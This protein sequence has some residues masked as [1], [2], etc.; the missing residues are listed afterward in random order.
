MQL[1]SVVKEIGAQALSPK[2]QMVILFGDKAT[3][4]LR[5][6][7]VIQEF[8]DPSAQKKMTVKVGDHLYINQIK[9]RVIGVGG[10]TNANL[11]QIGHATL[12]F[13]PVP[14]EDQLGN[15]IYLTPTAKP[16]FKVGTEIVYDL[17]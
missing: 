6:V 2:D 16:V 3:P 11:Q 5:D 8:A 17:D 10:I 7:S 13:Q 12:V 14:A 15:A 4:A 9:Y 1:K